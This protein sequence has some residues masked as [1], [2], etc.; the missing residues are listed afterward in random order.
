MTQRLND[1]MPN[2]PNNP[3][4]TFSSLSPQSLFLD[5]ST[6][7]LSHGTPIRFR[8]TGISMQPT[9]ANGEMIT[10]V[11]VEPQEI[12]R[13]DI[14]LYR[15]KTGVIAHRVIKTRV[16]KPSSFL[17]P[18]PSSITGHWLLGYWVTGLLGS[19]AQS[20]A[21]SPQH[22]L[23]RF[24]TRGDAFET[25]DGPVKPDQ[26]LGRVVSVERDGHSIDLRGN[27]A[28]ALFHARIFAA[29]LKRQIGRIPIV[30][31]TIRRVYRRVSLT[32]NL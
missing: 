24:L 19:L 4:T 5:V 14:I 32:S 10:I 11:P 25:P 3:M 28:K 15:T 6:N 12:K 1:P 9:I 2:G 21:L 13:G 16:I 27:K 30:A 7:M 31:P 26:I 17:S 22:S 18:Q 20:S 23:L 29:R 8:A